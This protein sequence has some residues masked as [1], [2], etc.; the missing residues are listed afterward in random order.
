MVLRNSRSQ[1]MESAS[2]WLVGS[3]RS[4]VSAS[5]YR[6]RASSMRRRWPPERVLSGWSRSGRQAR[7]ERSRRPRPRPRSRRRPGTR[8]RAGRSCSSPSAGRRRR[9]WPSLRGPPGAS[10]RRCP[11][12][13]RRGSGRGPA[14]RCPGCAGP[15]ADSRSP[16]A[17]DRAA[18]G[19]AFAREHPGQCGLA[20]TVTAHKAD[21]V[22]LVD[23]EAHLVHEEAGAGAQFEILDGNQCS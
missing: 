17:G 10:P 22:A 8:T 13:G 4:I 1:A 7:L 18:G 11:G 15:A 2:R 21:L 6:I 19:Q 3:S 23:P 5:E 14:A 12:R 16:R 9:R 20:C